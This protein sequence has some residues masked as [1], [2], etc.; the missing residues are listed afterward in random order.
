MADGLPL[1]S[2]PVALSPELLARAQGSLPEIS[3][4]LAQRYGTAPL[5]NRADPLEELIFIQLSIRTREETYVN[6]FEALNRA[7]DGNWARLLRIPDAELLPLLHGGGMASIK[8][9]RLRGQLVHIIAR[10]GAATLDPLH[11]WSDEQAEG[12]LRSLP[13]VGPKAA[14]CVM[15]YSLGR[16]VFPVDSH[17]RR[18]LQRL[19]FLP[20]GTDRKAADDI[21]QVLV[22]RPLRHD[23]HVNL[24]HH[25]RTL[26]VPRRPRCRECP[27]RQL[28]PVGRSA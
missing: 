8:L 12:F 19:G 2:G 5:G 25:G 10:F 16:H 14:R 1:R 15:L 21:L 4:L 3:A 20:S 18:V 27:L 17:C 22:P 11:D 9:A 7:L 26:C 24:V 6:V 28:C 13:G 23:L